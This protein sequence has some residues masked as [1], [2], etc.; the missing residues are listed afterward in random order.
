MK[1]VF[2]S[3]ESI[4]GRKQFFLDHYLLYIYFRF[5][6]K[7]ST[8]LLKKKIYNRIPIPTIGQCCVYATYYFSDLAF[9]VRK[10]L[11]KIYC[12]NAMSYTIKL[13]TR[14]NIITKKVRTSAFLPFLSKRDVPHHQTCKIEKQIVQKVWSHSHKFD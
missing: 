9:S 14:Y 13:M 1:G 2:F 3:C 11:N 6:K 7:L 5:R 12:T 8:I 10:S 4:N